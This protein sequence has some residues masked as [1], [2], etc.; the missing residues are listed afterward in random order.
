M[1][2]AERNL[3]ERRDGNL[4]KSL[5][6]SPLLWGS[7]MTI[8]FYVMCMVWRV[9]RVSLFP[10]VPVEQDLLIRYFCS[11]PLEYATTALFF[12]G[13]AVLLT[14]A[15]R[16]KKE[17]K[18][19]KADIIEEQ[20]LQALGSD[21]SRAEWIERAV[22]SH[23]S[24][25]GHSHFTQR[26][27]GICNFI[28]GKKSGQGI[29]D[30]L[31]YLADVASDRL[32]GSYALVR[33]I[34]WAVPIL[35]FLGTVIGITLAIA[36][37]NLSED[38]LGASL[39]SAVA[40]LAVAFDTTALALSLSIFLVF[41]TF[42]VERVEQQILD[43]IEEFCFERI[44]PLFPHAVASFSPLAD[45]ELK[46]AEQLL[47]QTESLIGRQTQLWQD[48]LEVLRDRW[49]KTLSD[50]QLQLNDLLKDGIKSTL[51]DHS[52]QLSDIRQEILGGYQAVSRELAASVSEA[53]KKQQEQVQVL[54]QQLTTAVDGF[55]VKVNSW[56]DDIRRATDKSGENLDQLKE[57]SQILLK[58]VGEEENLGRLQERLNDNL[59]SL[60][61]AETFEETLNTLSAAVQLMSKRVMSKAA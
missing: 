31:K 15:I 55:A 39:D 47:S 2:Q 46:A 57:Q 25:R 26:L 8:A 32:H 36:N 9:I 59:Q 3:E 10:D 17:R 33:T 21:V 53:G 42:A 56:Q 7:A 35:G 11:H 45:A 24:R 5:M 22:R 29:E 50:Q 61:A 49:T 12:L 34:T 37:L 18:S 4:K 30:Q 16:L 20:E 58:I 51:T 23:A 48:A 13:M 19:L 41:G 1:D 38:Q 44:V 14:K 54:G 60:Q 28:R 6:M 40:G 52:S 43:Q 27:S